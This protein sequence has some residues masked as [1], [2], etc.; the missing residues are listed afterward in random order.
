MTIF[1]WYFHHAH[2]QRLASA[3]RK[4][5]DAVT[6]VQKEDMHICEA[7][8]RGLQSAAYDRGRYS[9]KRENGV[10]HFHM[11]LGEISALEAVSQMARGEGTAS[12]LPEKTD[13]EVLAL[14]VALA[15]MPAPLLL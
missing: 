12:K 11:R 1:E 14:N 7:V 10:Y 8:Q 3:P 13:G 9:V 4:P 15:F 2:S 6:G 5:S